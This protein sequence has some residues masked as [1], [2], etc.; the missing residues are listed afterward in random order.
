MHLDDRS[1]PE[2]EQFVA[3]VLYMLENGNYVFNGFV[4]PPDFSAL[5]GRYFSDSLRLRR[6]R[7]SGHMDLSGIEVDGSVYA[8]E[9][10]GREGESATLNLSGAKGIR[11]LRLRRLRCDNILMRDTEAQEIMLDGTVLQGS[12]EIKGTDVSSAKYDSVGLAG[13]QCAELTLSGFETD[14]LDMHNCRVERRSDFTYLSVR[15]RA[16]FNGANFG[17]CAFFLR[18][19]FDGQTVFDNATFAGPAAFARCM[20]RESADFNGV[21]FVKP[22]DFSGS[23]EGSV[24]FEHTIFDESAN[25]NVVKLPEWGVFDGVQPESG[26]GE[27]FCVF[28]ARTCYKAG[29]QLDADKWHVRAKGHRTSFLQDGDVV[30]VLLAILR[31]AFAPFLDW[32]FR[33]PYGWILV[34]AYMVLAIVLFAIVF[35]VIQ[36]RQDIHLPPSRYTSVNA[37][38][39][40]YRAFFV[41]GRRVAA[42]KDLFRVYLPYSILVF[43]WAPPN[44]PPDQRPIR[45]TKGVRLWIAGEM[46]CRYMLIALLVA[47][48]VRRLTAN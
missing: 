45:E 21:H 28:A 39:L 6:A 7:I 23:F 34:A 19:W 46:L 36:R 33:M 44:D 48:V 42:L 24:S 18:C 10:Q 11:V 17:G 43:L 12:L 8:G 47:V 40:M 27:S 20:F 37:W 2:N 1:A 29:R 32:P 30:D 26:P 3:R 16:A 25:V 38:R 9:L 35:L 5:K 22:F 13:L 31:W 14:V 41:R 4:F 15:D